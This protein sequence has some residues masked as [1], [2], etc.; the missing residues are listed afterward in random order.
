M[1]PKGNNEFKVLSLYLS[2]YSK[3]FHLREI[4]RLAKLPLKMT[5]NAVCDLE[6]RKVLTSKHEG[7]NKYLSLNLNTIQTKL[8]LLQSEIYKTLLFLENYPLIKTFLKEIST[9]TVLVFGSFAKFSAEKDSDIDMMIISNTKGKLPV[10][11]MPYTVHSVQLSEKSFIKAMHSQETLMSE[12]EEN[13]VIL[14][15]HS[16]FV[17]EWWA[18]HGK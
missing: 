6:K 10:H 17:N 16:F 14:N 5:Q 12:I 9:C 1:Y 7:R 15:N 11:L 8:F 3:R 18:Y 2:G 4:S 13:H